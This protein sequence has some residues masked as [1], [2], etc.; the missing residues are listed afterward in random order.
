MVNMTFFTGYA[1]G[2]LEWSRDRT[3]NRMCAFKVFHRP[4]NGNDPPGVNFN[5]PVRIYKKTLLDRMAEGL[6]K[7]DF[8]LICGSVA[9]YNDG[10]S[11][12]Q[13][14]ILAHGVFNLTHSM[15]GIIGNAKLDRQRQL[16][17][18][19]ENSLTKASNDSKFGVNIW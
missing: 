18:L 7:G 13:G 16:A 4:P 9:A 15:E 8:L 6:D 5:I 14:F 10:E 3:G 11:V 12:R 1:S 2:S 17:Q 19:I